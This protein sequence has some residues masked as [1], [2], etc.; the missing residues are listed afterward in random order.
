VESE[1]QRNTMEK[2]QPT[3]DTHHPDTIA[4]E[5]TSRHDVGEPPVVEEVVDVLDEMASIVLG[6]MTRARMPW[7]LRY[8][9]RSV[10]LAVFSFIS[11]CISIGLMTAIAVVTHS[12]FIFPSLGPTAFLFF[13]RPSAP[14]ASPRNTILGHT[15]GACVGYLCLVITNLTVAGPVAGP[16]LSTG[17][18]WP[19]ILAAA[20]SLGLTAGLMILFRTPHPP[21][22]A[23]TLI[24]SLGILT[25]PWQLLVL[26]AAVVVLTLQ[27]IAINRLAGVPYPLWSPLRPPGRDMR[28]VERTTQRPQK[29]RRDRRETFNVSPLVPEARPIALEAAHVYLE[30]TRPWF[31]GLL[32]HGSALKGGVIRGCSDIDFQLYLEDSAFE[33]G[34]NLPLDLCLA[35]HKDL[36]RINPAPFQYIQCYALPEHVKEPEKGDV[37][38]IPGTYHLLLGTLPV[39]EATPEQVREKAAR[40]LQELQPRLLAITN[41]LLHYG[42]DRLARQVRLLCTDVWPALYNVLTCRADNPLEVWKLPKEAAIALLPEDE[43]PGREIRAFYECVKGYYLRESSVEAALGVIE[44][45][46]RFLRAAKY[47]YEMTL[48]ERGREDEA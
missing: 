45:G 27:A 34:G 7:L 2:E 43:S 4:P 24:V 48:T 26:M 25:Q 17:L 5:D 9:K 13:Y 40:S 8:H 37:R 1:Q 16:A 46:V 21:A 39:P 32:V 28:L 14:A 15:I 47:W 33:Q 30:H 42:G 18:T 29:K 22:G 41:E 11:G 31:I 10:V 44:Q 23:T 38:P 20:L 3:Q 35:I 19:R 36:S 6:L 12:P